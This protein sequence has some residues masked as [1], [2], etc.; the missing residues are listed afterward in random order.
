MLKEADIDGDGVINYEGLD[1]NVLISLYKNN[2]H[3]IEI[4]N[5]GRLC[6]YFNY[7]RCTRCTR[8]ENISLWK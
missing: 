1:I 8:K 4:I 3:N 5:G 2:R 7:I 6:V